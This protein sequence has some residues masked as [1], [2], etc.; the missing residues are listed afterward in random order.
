VRKLILD[1]AL[2][3]R[4]SG[5]APYAGSQPSSASSSFAA[6]VTSSSIRRSPGARG[7]SPAAARRSP[8][9]AL[10]SAPRTTTT[11]STRFRNSGRKRSAQ[12]VLRADVRVMMITVLR[13]S[14][15]LALAVGEASVVEQLQRHIETSACAF[16]ISS[17][18][19]TV[20]GLRQHGLGQLPA[21]LVADVAGRRANE[22]G[23]C[24]AL[25]CSD[26][27]RRTMARSS[28]NMNSASARSSV[29]PTPVGPR[30]DERA[31]LGDPGLEADR[32]RRRR[33][34]PP[35]PPGPALR[36][37]DAPLLRG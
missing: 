36:R 6:S 34:R 7:V 31:D 19:R 11:S 1:E 12:L 25:G 9:A 5:R 28:S 16:S 18:R 21:L 8:P 20:Y 37:A 32:A 15:V 29:F 22:P 35:R 27:S 17:R 30:K 2:I 13:K 14:T 23:E 4:F 26:M 3:A 10:A 24:G 33:S